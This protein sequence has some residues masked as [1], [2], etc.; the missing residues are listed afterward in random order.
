M[1]FVQERIDY[2]FI[3]IAGLVLQRRMDAPHQCRRRSMTGRA[4]DK[5]VDC[6]HIRP[7]QRQIIED[8]QVFGLP[9][10]KLVDQLS[11]LL[12]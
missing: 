6:T 1:G 8:S 11:A 2:G 7:T 4:V 12:C 10:L 3:A 9:R 5:P